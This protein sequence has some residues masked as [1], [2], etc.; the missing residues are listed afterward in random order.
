MPGFKFWTSITGTAGVARAPFNNSAGDIILRTSDGIHFHARTHILVESSPVFRDKLSQAEWKKE[1]DDVPILPVEETSDVLDPLLRLAYPVAD[2]IFT[3]PGPIREVLSAAMK[4]QMEEAIALLREALSSHIP[5]QPFRVWAIAYLLRLEEETK[6]AATSLLGKDLPPDAPKELELITAVG[7]YQLAVFHALH[8]DVEDSF[9]F[10]EHTPM[11][12]KVIPSQAEKSKSSPRLWRKKRN[13]EALDFHPLPYP[14]IICRSWDGQ[15]FMAHRVIL[16][17]VSPVLGERISQ[18]PSDP[19]PNLDLPVL[20][21]AEPA[22]I[23]GSLL[24]LCYSCDER[25]AYS[26]DLCL[27]SK[28]RLMVCARKYKIQRAMDDLRYS[29]FSSELEEHPLTC[30][31]L[32]SK[33]GF[34]NLAKA[35]VPHLH[36]DL[37]AHG[38]VPAMESTAGNIYHRL[39]INRR[40][41]NVATAKLTRSKI[42]SATPSTVPPVSKST[43]PR[44][45]ENDET[46]A[47][48]PWLNDIVEQTAKSLREYDDHTIYRID[49]KLVDLLTVSLEKSVWCG[50]C[51]SNLRMMTELK[52]M[53]EDV[54]AAL[55]KH[56]VS[57]RLIEAG[58]WLT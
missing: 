57:V 51:G 20:H 48:L 9:R 41:L 22:P 38:Y 36:G 40:Q 50:P 12:T 4:Y 31:L 39:L 52:A 56:D 47:G 35:A 3:D 32:A 33:L 55:R 18:L 49:K 17:L 16:S 21:L 25:R 11:S 14:D 29:G 13:Q 1:N 2:P 24:E 26:R 43:V 34:A 5:S 44:P 10:W 7:V 37:L 27:D 45:R 53:N 8:G 42:R 54:Y 28:L 30:Y 6:A 19:S 15:D 46:T 23:L 58:V